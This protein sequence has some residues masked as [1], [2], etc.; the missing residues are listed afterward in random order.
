MRSTSLALL[1]LFQKYLKID[2]DRKIKPNKT[3]IL[4][5]GLNNYQMDELRE[6]FGD[7]GFVL[8]V[9][10]GQIGHLA[11]DGVDARASD[12]GL[13]GAANDEGRVEGHVAGHQL[14][15]VSGVHILVDLK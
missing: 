8:R 15:L 6:L 7:Q 1:L 12:H 10:G 11:H 13:G 2:A 14:T 4:I 9:A 3:F 5:K